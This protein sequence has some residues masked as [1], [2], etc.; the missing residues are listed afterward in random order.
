MVT[1]A[2]TEFSRHGDWC[3]QQL[4]THPEADRIIEKEDN[5][6]KGLFYAVRAVPASFVA[7]YPWIDTLCPA[8]IVHGYRSDLVLG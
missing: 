6:W 2:V 7:K 8:G 5:K 1:A 3:D 4:Q